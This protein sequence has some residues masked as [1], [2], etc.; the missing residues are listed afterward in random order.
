MEK[1]HKLG[2][3]G[4]NT[5][6]IGGVE[7]P[8]E[9]EFS[10]M[11]MVIFT[12]ENF[13]KIELTVS[14][15]TFI[16]TDKNM[17]DFGKMICKMAQEKK[18]LKMEVNTMECSKMVK[19]GD[20]VLIN[21]LMGQFILEIGLIIILKEMVSILGQMVEFIKEL[22]KKTSSMVEESISGQM[23]EDMMVNMNMIRNMGLVHITGRMEKLMKVTGSMVSNMEKRNLPT[24]KEEAN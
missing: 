3:M 9:K 8:K 21:G 12:P 13:S 23:V 22:G 20:K 6:V 4:R 14:E 1:G 19:N 5:L 2:K 24:Q 11:L 16:K 17:K 7:W 18:N 10:T 15:F